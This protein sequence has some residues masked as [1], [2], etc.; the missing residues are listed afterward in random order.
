MAQASDRVR[1]AG[2]PRRLGV[3]R[4]E[5]PVPAG[6]GEGGG[7][8]AGR[9][10][11]GELVREGPGVVAVGVDT[12]RQVEVEQLAAARARL[13][14]GVELLAGLPLRNQVIALGGRVAVAGAKVAAAQARRPGWP[15]LA[16][17]LED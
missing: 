11:P 16:P 9:G 3:Q 5:A 12:Q 15:G 10:V 7:G 6:G 2:L 14:Q 13:G 17:G 4:R 1:V 8:G